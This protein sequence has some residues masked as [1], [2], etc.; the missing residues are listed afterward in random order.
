MS[1]IIDKINRASKVEPQPMGFGR[2]QQSPPKP[3]LQLVAVLAKA[4]VSKVDG[5][6]AALL[7]V[8]DPD[9]GVKAIKKTIEAA[10]DVPW[11]VWL[12]GDGTAI[13]EVIKAGADFV[14]FPAESTPITIPEEDKKTGKILELDP[15]LNLNLLVAVNELP[16]DAV[17]IDNKPDK[18]FLTW[19]NIMLFQR[20]ADILAKPLLVT[21]PSSVTSDEL[22][23]L[24]QAGV[25]GILI[26][27]AE[28][29]IKDLRKLIEETTF[30]LPRKRVKSGAI[31][32][33]VG[34]PTAAHEEQEEE[35]DT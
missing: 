31:I 5:A 16:V 8:S 35:E 14:V 18:G 23:A 17:I 1:K 10:S 28:G 6:D 12:K 25:D 3:K 7:Q 29:K 4:E 32:P 9:T 20:F 33:H 13:N 2:M 22:K 30:N 19:Q 24:W 11:G 21:V 27:A 34:V 26:D 15:A